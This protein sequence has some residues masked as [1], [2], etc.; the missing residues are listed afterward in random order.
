MAWDMLI[1]PYTL[2]HIL[3]MGRPGYRYPMIYSVM[4]FTPRQHPPPWQLELIIVELACEDGGGNACEWDAHKPPLR[5]LLYLLMSLAIGEYGKGFGIVDVELIHSWRYD[6]SGGDKPNRN[7]GS[8]EPWAGKWASE[9]KNWL[10]KELKMQGTMARTHVRKVTTG[11]FGSSVT[12]TVNATC[13]TGE[14][15]GSGEKASCYS[16]SQ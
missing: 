5:D 14:L 12:G 9:P 11:R 1:S 6:V 16:C 13:S 2:K 4:M 8:G 15:S 7:I 3:A 10:T